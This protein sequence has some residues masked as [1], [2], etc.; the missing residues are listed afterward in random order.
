MTLLSTG[1]FNEVQCHMYFDAILYAEKVIASFYKIQQEHK[2]EM[3]C[4]VYVFVSNSMAY[5]STKNWQNWITSK[6]SQI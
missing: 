5:V 1:L 6:L 2:I 3:S 4:A